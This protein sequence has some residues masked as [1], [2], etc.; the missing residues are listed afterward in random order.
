MTTPKVQT[1][2]RNGA[3]WYED[4][5]TG[6]VVPG[7]T[8]IVDTLAKPFLTRWAAKECA[9]F[10][11]ENAKSCAEL[12]EVDPKAVVDLVKQA[13]WRMSGGAADRGTLVHGICEDISLG[14]DPEVPEHVKG[15]VAGFREFLDEY[16]PEFLEVEATVWNT[17]PA[18][19][20]TF[21]AL[22]RV[23]T[24]QGTGNL[25]V[26]YKT[27]KGVYGNY[28]PQLAAY[29][30]APEIIRPDGSREP[31]PEVHGAAVLWLA[32]H[33]W[34]LH[35]IETSKSWAAFKGLH[36]A[37]LWQKQYEKTAVGGPVNKRPAK[38][39]K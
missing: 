25:L 37:F 6:Q 11:A 2:Y 10:V 29:A 7:V 21:D 18:Y 34:A 1:V 36:Q 22:V 38:P 13:P 19:A 12:A 32:E 14:K 17:D 20:G 8:S 4:P 28:A 15:H 9:T 3:R 30:H 16:K 31:M 33:G 35:P 23:E 39:R 27:S 26:D 5:A 24:P